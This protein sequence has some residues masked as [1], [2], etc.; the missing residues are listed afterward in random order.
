MVHQ[1]SQYCFILFR[2][3]VTFL[4]CTD[5]FSV[6]PLVI[7]ANPKKMALQSYA[8]EYLCGCAQHLLLVPGAQQTPTRSWATT[9]VPREGT[10]MERERKEM[11]SSF[12]FTAWWLWAGS[13]SRPEASLDCFLSHMYTLSLC[14]HILRAHWYFLASLLIAAE[15]TL[16]GVCVCLSVS[17]SIL[18]LTVN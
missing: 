4:L 18:L 15:S 1:H 10:W 16:C 9:G 2:T 11:G 8:C 12:S 6:L 14:L 7:R 17:V 5:H 13:L 3:C